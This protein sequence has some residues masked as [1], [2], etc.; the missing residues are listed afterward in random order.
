MLDRNRLSPIFAQLKPSSTLYINETVNRLWKEGKQVF[1]MGF[2]E[3]RFDVHPKLQKALADNAHKK[4]Y[5][6][7]RGL[8]EL[9]T[10]VAS[11]YSDKLSLDVQPSQVII[12]PGSK[13]LIY[14]VQMAMDADIFLPTPSWVS[15]GP[16]AE[17]LNR[18]VSYIPASA[19]DGY[20]FKIEEFDKLVKQ[21]DN[22]NKLLIINSPNN[23][24]GKMFSEEFLKELAEYCRQNDVLVM[25]DEIYFLVSHGDVEHVSIAK[26]YPEGTF[27]LGGL[28]KH[29]S[30]GGW[31][32]GVAVLP[33]ND[34]G[35]RV[36]S[37]LVVIASEIWSSVAAPV[38]Y[39]ALA[40]YSGD[41]DIEEYTSNCTQ[42][43]GIRSRFIYK[44][45]TEIGILCTEPKGAFY[46]TANFDKW[47]EQLSKKGI[48]TS[49]DLARYLLDNHSIATL[50]ADSFGVPEK[51]LSLRLASSYLDF[52]TDKDSE[53]IYNLY[54]SGISEDELMSEENHPSVHGAVKAFVDF[55]GSI[56][57]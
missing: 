39:A 26:Y 47:S 57:E 6:A 32:V 16:Q 4:S 21:S 36:M 44:K 56:G 25:S 38:Q 8:P 7:A 11:Y 54:T 52:E 43:H 22:P 2:G 12:G 42:I 30:I 48:N 20:Q 49:E 45:L 29:L 50:S 41:A 14:G 28:S 34:M 10:A 46:V 17:L 33:D 19:E 5:L 40:A 13:A 31:R 23:P 1:H 3:S 35:K 37:A 55:V 24:T 51:N 27:V 53:R 9:C 15:Y 18:K